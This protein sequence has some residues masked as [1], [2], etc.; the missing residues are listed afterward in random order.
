MATEEK[1]RTDDLGDG[2]RYLRVIRSLYSASLPLPTPM[3]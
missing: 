2:Y 1:E 3:T